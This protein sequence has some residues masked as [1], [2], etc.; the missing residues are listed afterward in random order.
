MEISSNMPVIGKASE[1]STLKVDFS[2]KISNDDVKEIKHEIAS[3]AQ[4]MMLKSIGL[5]SDTTMILGEGSQF[6]KNHAGF[7]SFLEDIGYEKGKPISEL[8][9]EEAAELVS[10]DGLFGIKQTAQRISDFVIQ[11]ANGDEGLLR[12]GREGMIEGFKMAEQMWGK[13]LPEISQKT[14]QESLKT[15]NLAM[16]DL[17]FSIIDKQV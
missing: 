3:Q 15:V 11:G 17:G 7:Q 12:A 4:D 16:S 8:S 6:D 9:Q 5:Q 14:M 10:E 13:E 2:Q 1:P